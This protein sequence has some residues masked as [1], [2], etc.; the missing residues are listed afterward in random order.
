MR[1]RATTPAEEENLNF[2]AVVRKDQHVIKGITCKVW[3]PKRVGEPVVMRLYPRARGRSTLGGIRHPFSIEGKIV[4]FAPGDVTTIRARE[5]WTPRA[6]MRH[7][8]RKRHETVVETDVM[9]PRSFI[10]CHVKRNAVLAVSW[11]ITNYLLTP[12]PALDV[13]GARSS[14]YT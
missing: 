3:L 6:S 1:H 11:C 7:H 12:C 5:V 13:G 10:E 2:E 9:D 4:G 14:S 8:G